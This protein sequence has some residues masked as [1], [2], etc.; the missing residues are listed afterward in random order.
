MEK[1]IKETQQIQA[2]AEVLN[3]CWLWQPLDETPKR[4]LEMH[5]RLRWYSQIPLSSKCTV[6]F[7]TTTQNLAPGGDILQILRPYH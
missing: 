6:S 7:P 3:F 4:F 2:L 1:S 5:L